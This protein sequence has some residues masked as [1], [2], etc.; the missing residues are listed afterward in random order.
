MIIKNQQKD[1]LP[2]SMTLQEFGQAMSALDLQSI[3][4]EHRKA[5]LMDHLA[6]IM[7]EK[8]HDRPMAADLASA[9]LMRRKGQ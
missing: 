9:Y 4:P 8:I 2:S 3:P 6:K 7:I 5:A 1:A